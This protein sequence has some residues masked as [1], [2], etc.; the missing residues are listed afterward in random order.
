MNPHTDRPLTPLTPAND[1]LG[2]LPY[3]DALCALVADARD[4]PLTVG[5][6]GPWGCGKTTLLRA[7]EAKLA[8]QGLRTVWFNPWPYDRKEPLWSALLALLL[9][10][11]E[12]PRDR[13]RSRRFVQ[14]LAEANGLL[15]GAAPWLTKPPVG[16]ALGDRGPERPARP[17]GPEGLAGFVEAFP[18]IFEELA[19]E[20]AGGKPLAVFIDDLDRCAPE[21]AV[22]VLEA[23]QQ[24][25]GRSPCVFVLAADPLVLEG[26]VE[27][28]YGTGFP[29]RGYL[30]R[31]VQAPFPLP[32]PVR[33]QADWLLA[34]AGQAGLADTLPWR[35]AQAV[36]GADVRALKRFLNA[37]AATGRARPQPADATDDGL[38]AVLL[39][40]SMRAPA[41]YQAL[42]AAPQDVRVLLAAAA[43][44]RVEA[45]YRLRT[46]GRPD[47]AALVADPDAWQA[48]AAAASA[49][50]AMAEDL[51][52]GALELS[53]RGQS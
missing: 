5:V 8:E 51:A 6:Y 48:L 22:T 9:R 16:T 47:L 34:P 4:L 12:A 28:L 19:A 15:E 2:L 30:D 18:A 11:L 21:H 24:A 31:L 26:A 37:W 23:L 13:P 49:W 50:P 43:R 38:R 36:L 39:L 29:A 14:L 27:R 52:E 3:R 45:E 53:A 44:D 10:T 32:R 1:R 46:A 25:L 20:Y 40:L 17:A 42:A 7:A 33:Q 35:L 41:A